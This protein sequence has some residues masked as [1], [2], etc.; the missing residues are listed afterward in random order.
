MPVAAVELHARSLAPLEKA[1]GLRDDAV[2]DG[3]DATS[4]ARQ[5]ISAQ[6]KRLLILDV[7][8]GNRKVFIPQV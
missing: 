7:F 2:G 4:A 5:Q 8:I 6:P 3:V 1:R